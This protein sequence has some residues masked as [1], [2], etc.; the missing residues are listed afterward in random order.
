MSLAGKLLREFTAKIR[1]RGFAYFHAN[2]VEILEH[3]ESHVDAKVRGSQDY[4]VRLTLGRVSLDV[5]CTCPYFED[6]ESC[7]HIWATMLAA[8]SRQYLRDADLRSRLDLVFDDEAVEE[9]L[10]LEDTEESRV[11]DGNYV[12]DNPDR[13]QTKPKTPKEPEPVWKQQLSFLTKSDPTSLYDDTDDWPSNREILYVVDPQATRTSGKLT[14][15]ICYRERTMKGEWGKIKS[16]SIP[17][18]AI[19]TLKDTA[20]QHI[21]SI[22]SGAGDGYGYHYSG[23]SSLSTRFTL[24]TV[25][26]QLVLPL[27]CTTGRCVLRSS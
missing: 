5:A 6:G 17:L 3:S 19:S 27:M 11:D 24:S 15:E 4:L 14:V 18:G 10:E 1:G 16:Q 23:Y 13:F 7:K 22:L 2:K 20:D 25:L 26:E 21:L 8:D 12:Q 9:F